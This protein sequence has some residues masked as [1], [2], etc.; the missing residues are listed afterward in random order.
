M[1]SS[2]FVLGRVEL[3]LFGVVFVWELLCSHWA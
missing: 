2:A 1:L 3:S